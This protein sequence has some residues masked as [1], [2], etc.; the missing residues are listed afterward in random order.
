MSKISSKTSLDF[1]ENPI[2]KLNKEK[3][4]KLFKS[5][6]N[7]NRGHSDFGHQL[8]YN[9][10]LENELDTLPNE[11][12][13]FFRQS[14]YKHKFQLEVYVP[15]SMVISKKEYYDKNYMLNNL[16]RT[17]DIIRGKKNQIA[18]I[19]KETKKFSHQYEFVRNKNMNHQLNYLSKIEKLYK[20]KGYNGTGLNYKKGENIFNPSFLLDTRYGNN[21]QTDV[22]KYGQDNYKKEYKK[23]KW[24]LNKFDEFIQ[25]KNK[26]DKRRDSI[27]MMQANE[28]N[29]EEDDDEKQ[30]L[31]AQLKKELEEQI[32]IQ[33]M[34]RSEYFQHSSKIKNEIESIKNSIKNIKELNDYFSKNKT[35]YENMNLKKSIDNN[36]ISKE[37]KDIQKN[38]SNN[39]SREKKKKL[40]DFNSNIFLSSKGMKDYSKEKTQ[41]LPY[42]SKSNKKNKENNSKESSQ[43][44]KK[45]FNKKNIKIPKI[46][47]KESLNENK[48]VGFLNLSERKLKEIQKENTLNDLYDKLNNKT[49]N[50][51]FPYRQIGQYFTKYSHR[52]LPV[53]NTD[54]GSNIHGLVEDIQTI[55]N[56]NNFAG[57]AKLNNNA[58]RDINIK[59]K[60]ENQNKKVID[61]DY[62]IDLDN[63]ILGIHYDFTNKLLSNK[64]YENTLD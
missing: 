50:S 28:L 36:K 4:D 6:I 53:V 60:E 1:N 42:I 13:K 41:I 25:N 55:I 37:E 51:A 30:K 21:S 44:K 45:I 47:F 24:L 23:D 17:E 63:K 27:E 52:R 22:V 57:F 15:H 29:L 32:K 39:N 43:K 59:D 11:L 26:G 31:F 40:V 33:N 48:K 64:K 9:K 35:S 34:T 2:D 54:R 56:E 12:N 19:S 14:L 10:K 7:R 5:T 62:I 3:V 49:N 38:D 8:T 20:N 58:K 46:R 18:H 61:D 16:V